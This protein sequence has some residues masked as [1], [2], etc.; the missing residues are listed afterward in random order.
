[1]EYYG[2]ENMNEKLNTEGLDVAFESTY[3]LMTGKTNISS[4][5]SSSKEVF[6]LYDPYYLDILEL[7][8]IINDIIDYFIQTEEYEKCQELKEILESGD[9]GMNELIGKITLSEDEN[10][11]IIRTV[12]DTR[13][14]GLNSIDNLIDLFKQYKGRLGSDITG[15]WQAKEKSK[16]YIPEH[17]SDPELW[18][19]MVAED[20]S[21]FEMDYNIF[22]QWTAKLDLDNK[23]YYSERLINN[24]PLIPVIQEEMYNKGQ[25][26]YDYNSLV[27]SVIGEFICI[28]NYS[29][30]KIHRLQKILEGLGITDSEIRVKT[31]DGDK[32]VYTLVYSSNQ[33][34]LN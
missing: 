33:P 31:G 15:E 10:K 8:D 26:T 3:R 17:L 14:G 28:S 5:A 23:K 34:P 22:K 4:I 2:T 27:V 1:M 7:K 24:L 32:T 11:E 30:D 12:N 18:S 20:K 25:Y 19:L 13:T 29:Q 16:K 21:I 9:K 6:I